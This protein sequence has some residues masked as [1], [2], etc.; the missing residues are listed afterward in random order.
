[1]SARIIVWRIGVDNARRG[2]DT[3]FGLPLACTSGS[4]SSIMMTATDECNY[5]FFGLMN[6]VVIGL[7]D[8]LIRERSEEKSNISAN[9]LHR[10]SF[11]PSFQPDILVGPHCN[12]TL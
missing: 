7:Y 6:N 10:L 9:I 1:M 3:L 2:R 12:K 8:N 11:P 4:F 5:H